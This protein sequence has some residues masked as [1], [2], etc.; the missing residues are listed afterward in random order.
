MKNNH[1]TDVNII[2]VIPVYN[3]S[4]TLRDVVIRALEVNE[5]VVVVDDGSTDEGVKSL[6]G[7]DVHILH[8]STNRGKGAR[9]SLHKDTCIG[10]SAESLDT[11]TASSCEEIQEMTA[12]YLIG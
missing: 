7:L 9:V 3:H 11:N 12:R 2:V 4:K 6:E 1:I 5:A 8:H 10:S